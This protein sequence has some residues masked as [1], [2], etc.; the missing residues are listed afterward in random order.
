M[1][2]ILSF[3]ISNS[4]SAGYRKLRFTSSPSLCSTYQ[5]FNTVYNL[6]THCIYF[7][8]V[9]LSRPTPAPR[10]FPGSSDHHLFIDINSLVSSS[11]R[12]EALCVSHTRALRLPKTPSAESQWMAE[13]YSSLRGASYGSPLNSADLKTDAVSAEQN[14]ACQECGQVSASPQAPRGARC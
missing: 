9:S 4:M 8:I 14:F 6:F 2:L 13:S 3:L 5:F 1:L 12:K 11:W 10:K 7:I